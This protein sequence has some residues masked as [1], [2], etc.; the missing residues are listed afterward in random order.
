[1]NIVQ[2]LDA[3]IPE[4]PERVMRRDQPKLDTRIIAKEHIEEGRPVIVTK[5]PGT[6]TVLRFIPEQWNLLQLFDGI[7]TYKEISELSAEATG[8]F[9][10]EDDVREVAGFLYDNTDFI[11]KSPLEKNIILQEQVRGQ[12]RKKL[13]RSRITDFTDI[14]VKEWPN[15]DQ[16]ISW[17]YPKVKFIYTPAFVLFSFFLFG[18]MLWMWA[19]KFVEIWNDSFEFYNFTSKSGKDLLEFWFLFGAMACIHE[20]A[21]GLTCKHFGGN[22]EKM[23][24]T[25]M[26]FAPSF[27]CD[28]SQVWIYGGP[29]QRMATAIA[30]IWIDLIVCVVATVVW[31]GTA[32]G[33][34]LHDLAYKVMMVTGIGVSLLNLNPLIKLDGY[35]IFSELIREPDLK[36][37]STAYLSGLIRKKIFGLPVEVDFVPRRRRVF[38]VVY[39]ILSGMYGYLLLSFLMVLSFHIL[40]AYTPEWAFLPAL[41]IGYWVFKSKIKLLVKFMKTVYLDKKERVRA[42]LT[43]PRLAAVSVAALGVAFLPVWPQFV[44][45]RFVLEPA[46]TAQIHAEVAGRV[47]RVLAREGQPVAVGQGLVELSNLQLESAAAGASADL[48]VASDQ[49]NLALLR[50]DDLGPAESKRQEMAER[51]RTLANQVA[52]LRVTSPIPGVVVT[53]HLDDLMGTYL[54]SGAEIAEVADPST[55][56]ARI[57]IPE[58]EMRDVHLGSRVRLQAESRAKPLTTALRSVAPASTAIQPGLIPQDQLKGITPPHFYVGSAWLTNPG[59]LRE[60]MTGS[61]KILVTY[62][63]I[64][65]FTWVFGRDLIDRKVW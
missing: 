35:L 52:L 30:G 50:Y 39:A 65:G 43:V 58:F 27:F 32:T 11:C 63:S 53:P 31:W 10:S 12:R 29:V 61:A 38:Y 14:T 36:E 42:W 3:A 51:N 1:M 2:A 48:R 57:Y 33:M 17:L 47:T 18:V 49:A 21:H 22:V 5:L 62:R 55:M 19:D 37:K 16:Y 6:E 60:G 20:T 4:L 56:I 34:T 15:A 23:G 54:V 64:A 25:L 41:A 28:V 13:K 24:F 9:F 46:H 26:Y 40:Q 59:D 45:G 44:E 7:R 8:A